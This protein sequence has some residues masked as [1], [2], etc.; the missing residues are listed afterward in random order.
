M[1]QHRLHNPTS[2]FPTRRLPRAGFPAFNRYYENAKTAPRYL[3]R[4]RFSLAV[5]SLAPLLALCPRC[6][7]RPEGQRPSGRQDSCSAGTPSLPA[8]TR[9][10]TGGSPKFPGNPCASALLSD[11]GPTSTPGISAS[12]FCP[13]G[14]DDEDS[15]HNTAFGVLSH[16]FCTRCLRFVPPS[17]TTTQ[18]SLPAGCQPLPDGTFTHWVPTK[19]FEHFLHTHP[20]FL[21]FAWRDTPSC[22]KNIISMVEG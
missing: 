12:R 3:R 13:H 17:L 18:D 14:C 16:G 11:P 2:P 4:F 5:R 20:P 9:K 1:S 21:S 19:G 22:G 6:R 8:L 10:V 15:G 7:V